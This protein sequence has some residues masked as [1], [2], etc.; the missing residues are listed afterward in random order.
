M[1]R[2]IV[3]L[4]IFCMTFS[5]LS[6]PRTKA[7]TITPTE[8]YVNGVVGFYD[9]ITNVNDSFTESKSIYDENDLIIGQEVTTT[10]RTVV[11]DP[12]MK[13]VTITI[14]SEIATTIHGQTTI[15][16]NPPEVISF[17]KY[18]DFQIQG[19]R[20]SD[21]DLKSPLYTT[22]SGPKPPTNDVE[23]PAYIMSLEPKTSAGFT[24]LATTKLA[25]GGLSWLTHYKETS[26]S[27]YTL[28]AYREPKNF[29][30][31]GP[32]GTPRVKTNV[33]YGAKVVDFKNLA[34]RV[35]DA[36]ANILAAS[37]TLVAAGISA[38]YWWTVIALIGSAGA[39][40]IAAYQIYV[41]SNTAKADMN[42]AYNLLR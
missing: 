26:S 36:R 34:R 41:N 4:I 7:M 9:E 38:L 14:T 32:K 27:Y 16:V 1:K 29:M 31:D 30:L 11:K 3:T 19:V 20:V 39:A 28:T 42:E 21:E 15:Q 13:I 5:T 23:P 22:T 17:S 10:N 2:I 24:T 40:G 18:G 8:D 33:K 6:I 37:A 25:S 12:I 35:S